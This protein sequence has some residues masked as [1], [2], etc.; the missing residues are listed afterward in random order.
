ME[1]VATRNISLQ[2]DVDRLTALLQLSERKRHNQKIVYDKNLENLYEKLADF[3]NI[4]LKEQK[5]VQLLLQKKEQ[6]LK[7]REDLA[8]SLQCRLEGQYCSQCGYPSSKN[9]FDTDWEIDISDSEEK[10]KIHKM[11]SLSLPA[12][13]TLPLVTFSNRP[14]HFKTKLS[15][16]NEECEVTASSYL[17]NI[18]ADQTPGRFHAVLTASLECLQVSDHIKKNITPES[19]R[20]EDFSGN[21]SGEF[22]NSS[23]EENN[24][25]LDE[26]DLTLSDSP[27]S[28]GAS[29]V[30]HGPR[31][32]FQNTA[33]GDSCEQD[34]VANVAMVKEDISTYAVGVA[35]TILDNTFNNFKQN[36]IES[37]AANAKKVNATSLSAFSDNLAA[38]ILNKMGSD[39]ISS[40]SSMIRIRKR[41]SSNDSQGINFVSPQSTKVK[42]SANGNEKGD[43][44]VGNY[45]TRLQNG[46]IPS[47]TVV[48]NGHETPGSPKYNHLSSVVVPLVDKAMLNAKNIVRRR[49]S[50][51]DFLGADTPDK[52]EDELD[53]NGINDN[54]SADNLPFNRKTL[55]E[56]ID[57]AVENV[58]PTVNGCKDKL[59]NSA[60]QNGQTS[61]SDIR[62]QT[63][64]V[65]EF[66]NTDQSNSVV[67]DESLPEPMIAGSNPD[68]KENDLTRS[69][70]R[71]SRKKK[72]KKK[73]SF[74]ESGNRNPESIDHVQIVTANS[75]GGT[76]TAKVDF[77]LGS[78]SSEVMSPSLNSSA[79]EV[80]IINE[81]F[82]ETE[83]EED[84]FSL[85]VDM[86]FNEMEASRGSTPDT[87]D[88]FQ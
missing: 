13:D 33:I 83:T 20:S 60:L 75:K 27:E 62:N 79:A 55:I 73:A 72:K 16:V 34:R 76:K 63:G 37:D 65:F 70:K 64:T 78:N 86:S 21:L 15:P 25:K 6:Q 58:I 36:R 5:D 45:P 61:N 22:F 54:G 40:N 53:F 39:L 3:E 67:E 51:F 12:R 29:Y 48:L 26:K 77:N 80:S 2:K 32:S 8:N 69:K 38:G 41:E 52:L 74:N 19:E 66:N 18:H 85:A 9:K 10:S 43:Q 28:I 42:I 59:L 87:L 1:E 71:K 14:S 23:I 4:L 7:V 35:N 30:Y 68:N 56:L 88:G 50:T 24:E 44:S 17:R 47:P 84:K 31:P 81:D 82:L 46:S 49:S 11:P 57:Q